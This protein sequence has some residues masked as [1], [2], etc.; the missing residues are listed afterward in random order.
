M[1]TTDEAAPACGCGPDER[2]FDCATD[3]ELAAA[4][5]LPDVWD[6][7]ET[8][9]DGKESADAW[10]DR[11]ES[12]YRAAEPADAQS[13]RPA[14]RSPVAAATDAGEGEDGSEEESRG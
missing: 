2:C 12:F 10:F 8:E 1:S 7:P 14:P 6:D 5:P 9:W 4:I 11:T 3:E 13:P